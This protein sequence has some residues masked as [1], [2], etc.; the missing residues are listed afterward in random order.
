M[1]VR[2][3]AA[4]ARGNMPESNPELTDREKDVL[5]CLKHCRTSRDIGRTLGISGRTV[6]FH[7]GNIFRK[8]GAES[9]AQAV[10]AALERKLID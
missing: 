9:R 1:N 3:K 4:E 5:R 10:A 2:L 8:L 6:K 7:L